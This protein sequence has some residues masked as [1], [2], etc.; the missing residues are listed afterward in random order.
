M[1]DAMVATM[2]PITNIMITVKLNSPDVTEK[3]WSRGERV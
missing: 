1:P 3:P 2:A